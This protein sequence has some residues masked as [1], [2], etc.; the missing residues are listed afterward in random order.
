M[1]AGHTVTL[2]APPEN[3]DFVE[4][5]GCS[6]VPF[7]SN[8][9]EMLAAMPPKLDSLR[10]GYHLTRFMQKELKFHQKILPEMCEGADLI[11][12]SAM[13]MGN[14]STVAEKMGVPYRF[15]ICCPQVIPTSHHPAVIEKRHYLPRFVNK[16]SWRFMDA[17]LSLAYGRIINSERERMGLKPVKK[18]WDYQLGP[19]P[20][21][22][23]DA[24]IAPVP[25]DVK[26]EYVQTGYPHMADDRELPEDLERFLNSGPPPL[27]VGFGSMPNEEPTET[28]RTF[29]AAAREA[30]LRLIVSKGWAGLAS[31]AG[32]DGE[33]DVF[34]AGDVAHA[35]LFP[36]VAAVIHHGGAGT[37][38][39]A[40][41]AGV[42]Q[43]IVPHTL[44][45]F[46]WAEMLKRRRLS[47]GPVLG[48]WRL[49]EKVSRRIAESLGG[50]G[51]RERAAEL[52]EKL[53]AK[54][55]P[56]RFVEYIEREF[57]S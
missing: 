57:G 2:A 16:L 9:K 36:R 27:F 12:S 35:K 24:E 20:V 17:M 5:K 42:P 41:R 13:T 46:Y 3:K 29:T 15:I 33:G 53:R 50:G 28:A 11:L 19:C 40:A 21:I 25:S 44:D 32:R 51:Y 6:F 37:T 8:F 56:A 23:S 48:R 10:S 54:D 4:S 55:G 47:P 18:F 30:G 7:G 14:P 34:M 26:T 45:Q 43:I 31:V 49:K 38:A 39:T 1:A 22:A 52:G